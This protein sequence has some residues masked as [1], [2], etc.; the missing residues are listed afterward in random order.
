MEE[1]TSEPAFII[2]YVANIVRERVFGPQHE[3]RSGTRHFAPGAKVYIMNYLP[4]SLSGKKLV[5]G[6][7]RVSHR[8]IGVIVRDEWLT[9]VR[10]KKVYDPH[11]VAR[12]QREGWEQAPPRGWLTFPKKVIL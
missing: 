5:L 11:I 9:N 7:H 2:C 6:H 4:Y 10:L 1:D 3:K 12:V 8:L